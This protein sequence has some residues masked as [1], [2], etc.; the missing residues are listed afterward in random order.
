MLPKNQTSR[1]LAMGVLSTFLLSAVFGASPLTA[2]AHETECPFCTLPVVQDTETQDNEVV[3]RYGRK[4]IEYRCVYCALAEAQ[5]DRYSGDV[6]ILAP[7]ELK[8]KPVVITRKDGK[9][10]VGPDKAVFVAVKNSHKHCQ[11]TYRAF[12]N[13][14]AFDQHIEKNAEL[15]RDAKPLTLEEMLRASTAKATPATATN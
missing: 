11:T 5:S 9:W 2:F 8:G 14:A 3:L 12:T 7:S 15:L 10:S 6:T 4:R 13:R 1:R